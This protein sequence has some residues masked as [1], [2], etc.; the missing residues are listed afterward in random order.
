MAT[1]RHVESD[2]SIHFFMKVTF[3]KSGVIVDWDGAHGS[4]LELAEAHG[5]AIPSSCRCGVDSVCQTPLIDGEVSHGDDLFMPPPPGV[6]LP[7]VA[8]PI[9]DVV[10][11]A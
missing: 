10:L 8:V 1:A 9:T 6:C 7:C 4:L 2:T 11:D 5:V 3:R